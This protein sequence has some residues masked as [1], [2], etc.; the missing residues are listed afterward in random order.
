MYR[1]FKR[2]QVVSWLKK[3]LYYVSYFPKDGLVTIM[4]V[5]KKYKCC[6]TYLA[7]KGFTESLSGLGTTYVNDEIGLK[8]SIN[9]IRLAGECND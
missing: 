6:K 9:G 2:L 4:Q 3:H 8:I 5:G 7:S 1:L